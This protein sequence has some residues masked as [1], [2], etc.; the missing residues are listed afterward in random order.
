MTRKAKQ[1]D[2]IDSGAASLLKTFDRGNMR[3]TPSIDLRDSYECRS[4]ILCVLIGYIIDQSIR[5]SS[6]QN[7]KQETTEGPKVSN[8]R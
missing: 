6:N 4:T 2:V 8:I 7:L 1:V 3:E 5:L